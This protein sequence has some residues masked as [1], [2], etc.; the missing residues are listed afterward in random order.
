MPSTD[1]WEAPGTGQLV[2]ANNRTDHQGADMPTDPSK[3]ATATDWDVLVVG[4]GPSGLTTAISAARHG[5]SVL[6]VEKHPG[7]SRFPKATGLRPRSME[8]LRG[9]GLEDAVSSDA[10]PARLTMRI[11]PMLAVPGDEIDMG[12]PQ[13]DDVARLSPSSIAVYPQDRLE[14]LMLA[15]LLDPR[16]GW[17][18]QARFGRRLT[19]LRWSGL[20]QG[21]VTAELQTADGTERVTARYVVGADG[22]RSTVRDL[23]GVQVVDLGSEGNHLSVLF[24]ADLTGLAA[25]PPHVLTMTVAPGI[26]GMLVTT[27]ERDRWIYD[28]EWHPERGETLA[29]WPVERMLARLRAATGR[30]DLEPRV[31]GLF[32]WDFGAAYTCPQRVGPVFLVGDAAHR[33]T[34]RGATGMNT[35]IADGHNL[36]WKLAWTVRGLAGEALLDSYDQERRPVG[37]ANAEASLAT[38][39]GTGGAKALEHDFGVT[40]DSDVIGTGP[41][42]GSRAPHAW[43]EVGGRR[44]S[45]LDLFGESLVLLVGPEGDAWHSAAER[46]ALAGVPVVSYRVG[47]DVVDTDGQLEEAYRL[48][49]DAA[50][51][52]RPDGHVAW[53]QPA[54]AQSGS[55]ELRSVV[56]AALGRQSAPAALATRLAS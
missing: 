7:L 14:Q 37:R 6:L 29:D 20:D 39:T 51:L 30:S 27:G 32:P 24:R 53:Q 21:P 33:T 47:A 17:R 15:H 23:L 49:A 48:G 9:W 25:D 54:G 45:T 34:P 28:V 43:I 3:D 50:V 42:A 46:L 8:I 5:A 36:G 56:T 13:P 38:A 16:H 22:A 10:Q 31:E 12:L 1:P 41:L 52:V 19:D 11:T 40:Y 35:G 18:T 44:T 2:I 26:E 4:A 55:D